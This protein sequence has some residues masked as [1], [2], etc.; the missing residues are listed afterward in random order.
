MPRFNQL[1]FDAAPGD[2]RELGPAPSEASR[3]DREWLGK[4][5]ADRR[6]GHYENALRYYSRALELDRS[7][8]AGWVGQ[9]QMLIMLGEYP[10]AELWAGKALEL[11][12]NQP[13]LLAG[14]AQALLRIGDRTRAAEMIDGA[15]RQEGTSAYRWI[16][17]GE[18]LVAA[19]DDVDAHCFDKAVQADRDW[20]VPLEIALI[21]LEYDKPSKGLLRARQAAEA[22]PASFYPW[23]IQARCELALGFD[24]QARQS[25]A[26][27][28]DLSPRNVE[29]SRLLEGLS[30]GGW[31]I[32]RGL[33]RLF[34]GR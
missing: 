4:A 9:V 13:D 28:L 34:G 32:G 24:R 26:R 12:R 29:A 8:V 22:S 21:Y 19:R 27:C 1:E 33:R 18:M 6:R 7:L 5:D 30:E 2:E 31:S 20:L 17:R 15:L 16:V 3:D 14:R 11:F 10:E 23:L 25:L